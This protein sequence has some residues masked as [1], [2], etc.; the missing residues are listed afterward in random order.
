LRHNEWLIDSYVS[1]AWITTTT[2]IEIFDF[3]LLFYMNFYFL[4]VFLVNPIRFESY[5]DLKRTMSRNRSMRWY[6]AEG[7]P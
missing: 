1:L 2:E 5:F 7:R 3:F 4:E 6:I